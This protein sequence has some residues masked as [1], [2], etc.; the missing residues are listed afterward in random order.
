[1][2]TRSDESADSPAGGSHRDSL[3]DQLVDMDLVDSE[4]VYRSLG[5]L[6]L[7]MFAAG[8]VGLLVE[9]EDPVVYRSLGMIGRRTPFDSNTLMASDAPFDLGALMS[10][11]ADANVNN[12]TP[13][14][15]LESMPPLV[16]RQRGRTSL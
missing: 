6:N 11:E 14:G 9:D 5:S 2:L 8:P 16:C 3:A 4:P 10:N 7:N 1:M 12:D 13:P 15:W